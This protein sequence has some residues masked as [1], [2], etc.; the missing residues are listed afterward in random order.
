MQVFAYCAEAFRDSVMKAAGVTPVTSPPFTSDTFPPSLLMDNDLIVLTLHGQPGGYEWFGEADTGLP[1]WVP[2]LGTKTLG[3]VNL[4]WAVVVA[5]SCHA[6]KDAPMVRALLDAGAS[7]VIG[8]DGSNFSGRHAVTGAGLLTL[9][10]RRGLKRGLSADAAL[11]LA[12]TRLALEIARYT[13]AGDI[14][15][16]LAVRDTMRFRVYRRK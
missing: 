10:V 15:N 14:A 12:K 4:G 1:N 3:A 8:G 7:C 16:R 6:S 5:T 2:A 9:W 13:V 11:N